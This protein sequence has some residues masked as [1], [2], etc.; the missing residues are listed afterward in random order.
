MADRVMLEASML[1]HHDS[2]NYLLALARAGPLDVVVSERLVEIAG[3]EPESLARRLAPR[4]DIPPSAVDLATT[5]ALARELPQA[6]ETYRLP[7]EQ[8]RPLWY[9]GGARFFYDVLQEWTR[10][11]LAA[12]IL[13]E[14]WHFLT[15]ESWLFS[16]TRQ[17]FDGMVEAGGTAIHMSGKLFDR[18]VRTTLKKGPDDPLTPGNR[19]RAA[20]KWIAVGGP[21]ILGVVEPISGAVSTA[22]S[23]YFLLVDP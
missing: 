5:R 13:F 2:A 4:L 12:Q 6:V 15:A 11:E 23:G 14:E 17:A 7:P 1:L 10:D 20:A 16:K 9:D 19:V 21:A 22:A 18:V 8:E 3:S